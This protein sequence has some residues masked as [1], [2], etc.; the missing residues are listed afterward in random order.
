[1]KQLIFLLLLMSTTAILSAQNEAASRVIIDQIDETEVTGGNQRQLTSQ[2][3]NASRTRQKLTYTV[4]D[5][6]TGEEIEVVDATT[7]KGSSNRRQS[8]STIAIVERN[9]AATPVDVDGT[10]VERRNRKQVNGEVVD[11]DTDVLDLTSLPPGDYTISARNK[12]GKEKAD[13]QVKIKGKKRYRKGKD[14]ADDGK[15]HSY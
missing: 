8:S 15:R 1:M 11:A 7:A 2:V 4:I 13:L 6:E 3:W 10:T 12:R 9:E 14:N 5:N